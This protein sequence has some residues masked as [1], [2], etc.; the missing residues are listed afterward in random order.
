M[1][2]LKGVTS[3]INLTEN[4]MV[5]PVDRSAG[6]L[7]VGRFSAEDS[8]MLGAKKLSPEDEPSFDVTVKS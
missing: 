2:G 1:L 3:M 8:L 4:S 6:G 5:G 7:A